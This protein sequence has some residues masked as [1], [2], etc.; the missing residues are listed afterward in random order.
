MRR[1]TFLCGAAAILALP[2]LSRAAPRPMPDLPNI[3][4]ILADDLSLRDVGCY[5]NSIVRTPHIDSIARAGMRFNNVFTTQAI[6]APSRSTLYTGLYPVHHGCHMNHGSV[7]PGTRSLPHFLEPLG[8]RVGLAGKTH[9]KPKAA[10]PFEYL[11]PSEVENFTAGPQPF[12]LI[13]ASHEPHAPHQSGGYAPAQ[14]QIP[15]SLVDTPEMRQNMADYYTDIELFDKEVGQVLSLLKQ[16]GLERSTLTL[17]TADHGFAWFAKWTLYD[18]GL[19]VPFVARWPGVIEPSRVN[20]DLISFVDVA[21]TLIEL[22][23]GHAPSTLDGRSFAPLLRGEKYT[24]RERVFASHTNRGI[25]SGST[26]PIRAV[27]TPTHKYIRNLNSDGVFENAL[28][29][30]GSDRISE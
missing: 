30:N 15:P 22:A 10:F 14:M 16:R 9:I 8:Y 17:C 26:Y 24:P 23:G 11:Q 18:A 25:I 6:C 5:G 4:L 3:V 29:H 2:H 13:L 20:S 1:R 7:K 21:P 12:C 27:R 19:N 28:T